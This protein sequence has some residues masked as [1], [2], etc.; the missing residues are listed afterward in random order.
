MARSVAA[1]GLRLRPH[2]KSH[3]SAFIAVLQ[4]EH[5]AAGIA[6]AKV[7]EAEVLVDRLS[8]RLWGEPGRRPDHLP[9]RR[10]RVPRPEWPTWRIVARSAVVVDRTD[11]VGGAGGRD[12]SGRNLAHRLL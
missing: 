2:A 11:G 7:A 6:C 8:G 12:R 1:D 3:K 5:G 4:L 9:A 10:V